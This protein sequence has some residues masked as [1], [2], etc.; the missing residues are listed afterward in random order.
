[1]IG[2]GVLAVGEIVS[3]SFFMGPIAV[4]AVVAAIAAAAGAG[5]AIQ[6]VVFILASIATLAVIRPIARSHLKVP[7]RLRT[8]TQALVGAQA[9][10]LEPVDGRS[11]Q[12]K[13]AGEVWSARAFDDDEVYEPG[14]RVH[15][16]KIE[17]ATA[18]VADA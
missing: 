14:T 7:G 10:V 6:T 2:A 18:L 12:I 5:V 3:L 8:G 16:M 4:A 17:G 1:M 11:G 9:E 15:V 13:L